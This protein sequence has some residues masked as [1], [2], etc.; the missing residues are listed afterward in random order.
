MPISDFKMLSETLNI[1][2]GLPQQ[3]QVSQSLINAE[4]KIFS[5]PLT[6][7]ERGGVWSYSI[8]ELSLKNFVTPS[9]NT[10]QLRKDA[11]SKT[12]TPMITPKHG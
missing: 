11:Y 9:I 8:V 1:H 12:T 4:D 2:T 5:P 3:D 6:E 7:E 10:M